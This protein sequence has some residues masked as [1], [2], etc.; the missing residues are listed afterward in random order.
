MAIF[1]IGTA[2]AAF[3]PNFGLLLTGRMVQAIGGSVM[4]PLL[5]NVML[6]SFPREKRGTAMG[7]FGLVMITAP[8]IGPT[9]SGFIVQ[10]Y[11][12]RLLFEMILPLSMISLVLAIWKLGNVMP[13]N[14]EAHLDYTSVVL[15]S[16]GFG[17]LLYGFSS[18][19]SDGW[20]D[21]WVL[22]TLIVGVIALTAFIIRQLR[23]DEPLLD[24][25]VYKYPCLH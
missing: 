3:A 21:F 5:M 22:V 24:L 9:L 1:T 19:S 12:W 16:L 14:K 15:S 23:M 11:D 17:G 7:V 6:I 2:L 13:Q 10:N 20:T 8:A 4:G 25:R 18:A